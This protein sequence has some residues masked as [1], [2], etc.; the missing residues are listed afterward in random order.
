M[1]NIIYGSEEHFHVNVCRRFYNMDNIFP[2]N[3]MMIVSHNLCANDILVCLC[4]TIIRYISYNDIRYLLTRITSWYKYILNYI[5][6]MCGVATIS[7]GK[8]TNNRKNHHIILKYSVRIWGKCW[9]NCYKCIR[10]YEN[11][12]NV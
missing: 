12:Y 10:F 6:I 1:I 9:E 7:W 3:G 4:V 5:H 8:H 2:Y 11:S